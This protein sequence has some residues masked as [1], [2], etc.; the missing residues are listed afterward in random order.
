MALLGKKKAPRA[1]QRVVADTSVNMTT[2]YRS[3]SDKKA[4]PAPK[5]R[6]THSK[7]FLRLVDF[8][9]V[10]AIFGLFGYSLLISSNPKVIVSNTGFNSVETYKITTTE[11]MSAISARNKITFDEESLVKQLQ[12]RFP[13][14]NNVA[15]ELPLLSPVAVVRLDITK[16]VFILNN[17]GS[18]FIVGDNGRAVTSAKDYAS[19]ADLP[20][21]NDETG[22]RA[23]LGRQ[24]MSEDGVKFINQLLAVCKVNGISIQSITLPPIAQEIRLRAAGDAYFVKLLLSGD[25]NIQTGQYLAARERFENSE[26][27]SEYLDV[28][29]PG[30]I[31]YK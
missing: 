13:E 27:P 8:I 18:L 9:G 11:Y 10:L 21:V 22:Y 25:A 17:S 28:R 19:L 7:I 26:K 16:P 14:I 15:V 30:K 12:S 20:V 2:Y 31:Y 24:V 6:K 3:G 1:R 29:V 5:R 23:V 4:P